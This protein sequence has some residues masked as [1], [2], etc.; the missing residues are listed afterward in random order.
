[1]SQL[2]RRAF[3]GTATAFIGTAACGGMPYIP[4]AV[5]PPSPPTNSLNPLLLTQAASALAK[6]GSR[7][8]NREVMAIADFSQPSATPRFHLYN[9]ISGT[10]TTLLVAHGVGSDR[11][12]SGWVHRFSNLPGSEATSAGAYVIAG[13]YTGKYGASRRLIGLDADNDQAENRAIVIHPAWYVS[14]DIAARQGKIG[15]S[16][17]CFAFAFDDIRQVLARLA[18]GSLLYAGKV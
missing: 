6:H 16:Q 9:M 4:T 15:R 14:Q 3:L 2:G 11:E 17:G 7:I 10:S 1:M 8:V 18:P 13:D 12:H 5:R